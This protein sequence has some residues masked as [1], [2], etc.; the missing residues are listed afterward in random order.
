M[1]LKSAK[2]MLRKALPTVLTL[3][4][5][6]GVAATAALSSKA[7]IKADKLLKEAE[8][9]KYDKLTN[10][11]KVQ[12]AAPAYIPAI[13]AG[14]ATIACICG[15][16]A[17]D[18]RQQ[19]ALIGGYAIINA[20]QNY[21]SKVKEL[22]G[23][24]AHQKVMDAIAVEKA[25]NVPITVPGC[26][27]KASTTDFGADE[28][29]RLFFDAFSNRYFEST[30]GRVLQAEMHL[31][32]NYTLGADVTVNDF[33]SFLGLVPIENGDDLRWS[34]ESGIMWIDFNHHKTVLDDGLECCVID[35]MFYPEMLEDE[36]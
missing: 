17:Y 10:F 7:A 11:E 5:A 19:A 12:V 31:N 21:I 25:D 29:K 16:R 6:G 35:M 33:Y 8:A 27:S 32:R 26:I 1:K 3:L 9:S 36:L 30:I 14:V 23:E 4:S 34:P 18:R 24:E 28:E 22:Y 20:H 15:V 2:R 13:A